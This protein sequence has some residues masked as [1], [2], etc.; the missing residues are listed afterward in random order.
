MKIRP[1]EARAQRLIAAT[2]GR[3][4]HLHDDGSA[5][6][7]Y[8]LRIGPSDRPQV[9]IEVIGAV[10]PDYTR[11]WNTG[12]A[13]GPITTTGRAEWLIFLADGTV[14]ERL[15]RRIGGLVRRME[16]AGWQ[17][18]DGS[19]VLNQFKHDELTQ[20]LLSEGVLAVYCTDSDGS[21][22]VQFGQRGDGGAPDH[23]GATLVPWISAFL[24]HKDRKDVV[25]KLEASGAAER[26]V[27][28]NVGFKGAPFATWNYLV[29][30]IERLPV[31]APDLPPEVDQV[32]IW[33]G[34]TAADRRAEGV[35][36]TGTSW[37]KFPGDR[38]EFDELRG[39]TR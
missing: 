30:P 27:F 18:T 3:T 4:V 17:E 2:L 12:A 9:A 32:W 24:R 26:H 37:A 15:R 29:G 23:A 6:S 22:I 14:V 39:G 31:G 20:D 11:T 10:N 1:E 25:D 19:N 28:V 33:S 13:R 36:W 38:S 8:D 34:F 16:A 21:G 5:N 7:M 35:R